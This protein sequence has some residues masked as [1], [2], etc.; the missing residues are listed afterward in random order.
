MIYDIALI[1]TGPSAVACYV[2]LMEK[3]SLNICVLEAGDVKGSY[4]GGL[5]AESSERFRLNPTN[6]VGFGGTSELWHYVIAPLDPIDFVDRANIGSPGWPFSFK[7]MSNNYNNVLKIFGLESLEVFNKDSVN[8]DLKSLNLEKL[9]SYFEPKVFVQLRKR[10]RAKQF[11]AKNNAAKV[12]FNH[13][14]H[15]LNISDKYVEIVSFD[16]KNALN[17]PVKAKKVVICCGGLN[18][19]QLVYN[20]TSGH[21]VQKN[22]G[23]FLLDHPMGVGMQVKREQKYNFD[24]LTSKPIENIRKKIA[25]RLKEDLQVENSLPNSAFYYRPSFSE[26]VSQK[27]EEL[28]FKILSYRN[29]LIKGK[30]PFSLS[31]ELLREWNLVRQIISYKTGYLSKVD[32]FDIFCVTEQVDGK[33]KLVFKKGNNGFYIAKAFWEVS[34]IDETNN[35]KALELFSNLSLASGSSISVEASK[36]KWSQQAGSAAHHIGTLRMARTVS[37]GCVNEVGEV[38]GLEGKVSVADCSVMPSGGNANSTL[39]SMAIADRV[40]KFV[41][42]T[43]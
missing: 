32:L 26:G 28:K 37:E 5:S 8:A 9:L 30:I 14:V 13:F 20:S 35:L 16:Q 18:S 7:Q 10:W 22:V 15:G 12:Y 24:I 43:L 21:P 11:W 2:A 38:F 31:L 36:V 3:K 39:T 42:A 33:G 34:D 19:P 27:T 6:R 4:E 41:L 25:F 17:L 23:K 1:G 29:H 40:G